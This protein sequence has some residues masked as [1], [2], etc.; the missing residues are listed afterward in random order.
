MFSVTKIK[1]KKIISNCYGPFLSEVSWHILAVK[2][3][4]AAGR[5][6]QPYVIS[7]VMLLITNV[8]CSCLTPSIPDPQCFQQ[9]AV[10]YPTLCAC[11]VAGRYAVQKC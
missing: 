7:S 5:R 8:S 2:I 1:K 10:L 9:P 6:V 3:T 11:A 4:L